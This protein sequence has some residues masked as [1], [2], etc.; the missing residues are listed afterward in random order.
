[1]NIVLQAGEWKQEGQ[2]GEL[3]RL[4]R[5]GCGFANRDLAVS[6]P[7]DLAAREFEAKDNDYLE[8]MDGPFFLGL[9]S[10]AAAYS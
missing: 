8:M 5:F 3:W 7:N 9:P 10:A 1:M 2:E 4:L 6:N